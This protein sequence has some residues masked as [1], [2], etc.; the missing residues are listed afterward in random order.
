MVVGLVT[1][2]LLAGF[3]FGRFYSQP[4]V[5]KYKL[6]NSAE[7]CGKSD[8]I[9]KT[10]YVAVRNAIETYIASEKS[11]GNVASTSVY[12]RD[13]EDGPTF[14]I[15]ENADFA[16]ASLLKVPLA[17]VYLTQAEDSP[18]T[19]KA[20]VSVAKPEWNFSEY[21]PPSQTIDPTVPHTIEDLL[22]HMVTYSDN[23]AYGVLQT[24]LYETG[25]QD[26]IR[27]TF[28]ELGFI[29]PSSI[30]DETM[31]VRQYA[32]I[33]RALY[34]VSY[35]DNPLSEKV[36]EWL[37]QSDFNQGLRGGVP[38]DVVVAHKFGE[39]F[40]ESG[41]K[42]LHDCGIV[43]YPGNPYLLCIMTSGENFDALAAV[44]Q[45]ISGVIYQ[46]VDSRRIEK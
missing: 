30:Y 18:E 39:R 31:S 42:Q 13:L 7:V 46:E 37:A 4:C 28:L 34:N 40:A 26:S 45:H 24:H 11:S 43:Y 3:A 25:Q 10:D 5:S 2:G 16:P 8:V 15:R 38:P 17:L 27:Q 19:L 23:N 44:I 9:K 36:L 32:G 20:Q 41:V 12:F 22:A 35:L 33:F 6:I 21:Y 14:G 1:L 29:D